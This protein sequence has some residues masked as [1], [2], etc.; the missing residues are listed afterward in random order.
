MPGITPAH[1]TSLAECGAVCLEE[2]GHVNGSTL[3]LKGALAKRF[4][5]F[6]PEVTDQIRRTYNDDEE[7]TE[8]GA[9]CIAILL[10]RDVMC[11][12]EVIERARKGKGFDYWLGSEDPEQ[13]F[14][15]HT[16]ARLEVSGIRK[17]SA[18]EIRK[19]ITKKI[20]QTSVSDT[21]QLPA[22]VVIVEF[23]APVA[24]MVKR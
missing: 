21:L 9:C 2:Q 15:F 6:W 20:K 12:H 17:G 3:N 24:H 18:A 22:F 10:L 5:L 4:T 23:G 8:L 13:A 19:R 14:V 16:K 1:G 11:D 7:A